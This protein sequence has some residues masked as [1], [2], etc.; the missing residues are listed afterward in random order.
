MSAAKSETRENLK[1][2]ADRCI[3]AV[4]LQR[5]IIMEALENTDDCQATIRTVLD[6]STATLVPASSLV[7]QVKAM[8]YQTSRVK[9]HARLI[10]ENT[11]K[12]DHTIT[13][14]E[15]LEKETEK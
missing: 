8:L 6:K 2:D 1:A 12:L 14:L 9:T 3:R 10:H 13:Q 7:D 15:A 5:L 4:R 11:L